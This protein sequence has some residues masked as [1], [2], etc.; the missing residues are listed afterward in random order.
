M[1]VSNDTFCFIR[2]ALG[3]KSWDEA[4]DMCKAGG[5]DGL[6]ELRHEEDATFLAKMIYCGSESVRNYQPGI[7]EKILDTVDTR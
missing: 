3:E 2:K 6:L 7:K 1:P 4:I 5:Y